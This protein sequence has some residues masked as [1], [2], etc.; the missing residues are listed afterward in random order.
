MRFACALCLWNAAV[1]CGCAEAGAVTEAWCRV[2]ASALD[3]PLGPQRLSEPHRPCSVSCP[4]SGCPVP[5]AGL[6]GPTGSVLEEPASL[7]TVRSAHAYPPHRPLTFLQTVGTLLV[8]PVRW[9]PSP[10]RP[11]LPLDSLLPACTLLCVYRFTVGCMPE[12]PCSSDR[13]LRHLHLL[14]QCSFPTLS[15]PP[16]LGCTSQCCAPKGP[17]CL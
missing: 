13:R 12:S 6:I 14:V 16:R 5:C 7:C 10:C 4:R 9:S 2:W 3:W 8:L 17:T 11:V 15:S 1:W